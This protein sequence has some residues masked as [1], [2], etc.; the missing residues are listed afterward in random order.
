MQPQ[1]VFTSSDVAHIAKLASIPIKSDEAQ[2]LATGFTTTMK[3][4][5]Q[6]F[7]VD[8]T[9]V[10]PTHQ[11]T[12]LTNITRKDEVDV[13]RMFTQDHALQNAKRTYNGYFVADQVLEEK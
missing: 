6:L 12:G 5:D 8:V 7:S 4:V 3:V 11:V 1:K 13:E 9:G 10:E 2:K